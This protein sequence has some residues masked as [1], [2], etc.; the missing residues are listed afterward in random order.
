MAA[1]NWSRIVGAPIP[2]LEASQ[3]LAGCPVP[4]GLVSS[5]G[6]GGNRATER[7]S[8]S[9][10][11]AGGGGLGVTRAEA[12]ISSG[13]LR[14]VAALNTRAPSEMKAPSRWGADGPP[15]AAY[16]HLPGSKPTSNWHTRICGGPIDICH[17][18]GP[19]RWLARSLGEG[20]LRS[21]LNRSKRRQPG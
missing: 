10:G 9:R 6:W 5:R 20:I 2:A 1:P 8:G 18:G 13:V 14:G 21:E 17:W 19:A 16:D 15:V 12:W 11:R 4:L 3:G 7:R